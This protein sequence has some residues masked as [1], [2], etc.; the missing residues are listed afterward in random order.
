MGLI[1]ESLTM[2]ISLLNP[3]LEDEAD[4]CPAKRLSSAGA[5]RKRHRSTSSLP[6]LT[7]DLAADRT[8]A[9]ATI[10]G[11]LCHIEK[12]PQRGIRFGPGGG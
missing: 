11:G 4:A 1:P 7:F 12:Y 3:Q 8:T 2:W 6:L 5:E 9:P 10:L